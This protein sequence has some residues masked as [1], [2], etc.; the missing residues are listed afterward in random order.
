MPDLNWENE[1]TRNA[2]YRSAMEFWLQK[3]VDGFRI[4]TINLYSKD[5]AYPDAPIVDHNSPWQSGIA[6][7]VNGPRIHEYLREMYDKVLS[8]YDCVTVGE[9]GGVDQAQLLQYVS[10]GEKQIN[11]AFL[12]DVVNLGQG[13]NERYDTDPFQW[14]L[15]ELK[16][17][18]F[19]SQRL[20]GA[21]D[22]WATAFLE[23]HDQGRSIS[24]Y[25]CDNAE[26][27][28]RSGK[29]L[30]LM[31]ATLSGTL[32]IYQGQ[33]IGMVNIPKEWPIA[34]YKDIYS[35][36][37]YESIEARGNKEELDRTFAAIQIFAR[38]NARLP[39][40]WDDSP[41][42]GFTSGRPW[43]RPHDNYKEL[44]VKNSV[45]DDGSLLSFWKRMLRL[46]KEYAQLMIHG[47]FRTYD[48]QNGNVFTFTKIADSKTALVVLNFSSDRQSWEKPGD[49]EGSLENLAS[50]LESSDA[51]DSMLSP[52]EGRV[53]LVH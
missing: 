32:F 33:E 27:R 20:I 3:G 46:R 17:A 13:R 18:I 40:Q 29:M 24:R 6:Y 7:F 36:S 28:M 16:V 8:K 1:E 42:A 48:E 47:E 23:N 37:S 41:N 10:A 30:A 21:T 25:A 51:E 26:Y 50:T 49:I 22:A 35:R 38:D 45:A 34:E 39:M 9:L 52:W 2:I 15:P 44:N 11:M 4:D 31:L 19:Q 43:M 5:Q 53:Y 12:F 14:T